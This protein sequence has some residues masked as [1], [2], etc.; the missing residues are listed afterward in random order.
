M[1]HPDSIRALHQANKAQKPLSRVDGYSV[2]E[3][4]N[5]GLSQFDPEHRLLL[6][7]ARANTPPA[8]AVILNDAGRRMDAAVDRILDG[9]LH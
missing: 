9:V 8:V 1:L 2:A 5:W 6:H 4:R 3:L 7:L